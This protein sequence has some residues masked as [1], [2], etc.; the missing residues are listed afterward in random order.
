MDQ[1]LYWILILGLNKG[2]TRKIDENAELKEEVNL[3]K[4]R[5]EELQ[6][7]AS[8]AKAEL[9]QLKQIKS[10]FEKMRVKESCLQSICK[11]LLE[12]EH[13]I[14]DKRRASRESL[15]QMASM[16]DIETR[17]DT[18]NV[19]NLKAEIERLS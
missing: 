5:T 9:S 1:A 17:P 7:V 3:L 11:Q 14:M 16:L 6:A 18:D 8:S 15:I 4:Q 10:D 12:T 13:G 19:L 2:I